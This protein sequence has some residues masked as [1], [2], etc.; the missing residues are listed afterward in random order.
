MKTLISVALAVVLFLFCVGCTDSSQQSA[1]APASEP[2]K[3]EVPPKQPET[4]QLP[5]SEPE[6][7]MQEPEAHNKILVVCFSATGTTRGVAERIAALAGADFAEIIPAQPYT[8]EDL[9]YSDRDSR[10][11]A[12]QNDPDVRPALAEDIATDSYTTVFLGYPIWWGQAP[13]I[14]STF[15]ESRDFTGITVIPFCTSGSSDIGQSDDVLAAQAGSGK[16][17]QGR[18]F[19]GSAS[20]DELQEWITEMM[21]TE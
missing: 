21:A 14:L 4:H 20:D 11:T 2:E 3:S 19:S 7:P 10:A 16:W 15:V 12:E 18:R 17:L 5:E 1:P 6:A 13:R 9:N 8:E